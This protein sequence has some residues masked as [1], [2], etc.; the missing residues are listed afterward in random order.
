MSA[1]TAAKILTLHFD[2]DKPGLTLCGRKATKAHQAWDG[3][4]GGPLPKE[5]YQGFDDYCFCKKCEKIVDDE[6]A[7]EEQESRE[8]DGL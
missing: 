5:L 8:E 6:Q 7:R 3:W 4:G 1:A 2:T